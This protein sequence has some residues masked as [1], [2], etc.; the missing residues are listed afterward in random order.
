MLDEYPFTEKPLLLIVHS[1]ENVEAEKLLEKI[2]MD[3]ELSKLING[4]FFPLGILD[5]SSE[6]SFIAKFVSKKQH[7]CILILRKI[8]NQGK[9]EIKVEDLII[10]SPDPAGNKMTVE[11]IHQNLAK[12]LSQRN[13][14]GSR[15]Q[16]EE[17]KARH[18][19]DRK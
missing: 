15:F 2:S 5:T 14:A 19:H 13:Q 3:T 8:E 16:F 18:D 17:R 9:R 12:Y 10:L 1:P 11:K 4:C 7:P 6:A